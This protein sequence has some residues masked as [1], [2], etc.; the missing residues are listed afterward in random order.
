MPFIQPKIEPLPPG[1]DLTNKT[2]IVTGATAGIGLELSRQL[3][4]LKLSTLIL[5]V[6]NVSKGE[7]VRQGL[8]A[9]NPK[10]VVQVL[11]LDTEDYASVK[12]FAE[13]FQKTN[14]RLHLL[15]LNA[16][17]GNLSFEMATSGH[18]KHLQINY[19]SN[20]LLTLL[21]LP[22]LEATAQRDGSPTRITWTGSRNHL[23]TSLARRVPL[24]KGEG[25]FEHFDTPDLISP[26]IRYG[27]TKLLIVLSQ[28]EIAKRYKPEKVIMNSFCPAM[29]N[30]TMSDVLPLH[31][32]LPM[33]L[34]KAMRA[35]SVDKAGWIGLHAALVAGEET[36]GK[37]LFDKDVGDLGDFVPSDEGRRIQG[38]LWEET[39]EE[40][41]GLAEVP[42]W[43]EG[44]A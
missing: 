28:L 13:T 30:T 17:I 1:I 23:H 20:I 27:D 8:L 12:A 24:K 36:H 35:R 33:N 15:M 7:E 4:E 43:M 10:A 22:T 34:I 25:V 32:R 40:M 38:L 39:V 42:S 18:E 29:V 11:K 6:R 19:L 5:A 3:L 44:S 41:R 16:G 9:E 31:L 14:G 2:A 21:L 26:F 37:L